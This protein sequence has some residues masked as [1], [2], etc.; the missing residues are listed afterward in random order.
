MYP[1]YFLTIFIGLRLLFAWK[2]KALQSALKG[3]IIFLLIT[4]PFLLPQIPGLPSQEVKDVLATQTAALALLPGLFFFKSSPMIFLSE[5][6]VAYIGL[7]TVILA[8]I[9]TIV[10]SS[11]TSWRRS[12]I[13]YLL[14]ALAF[15]IFAIGQYSPINFALLV[16]K[17]LPLSFFLRAPGRAMIIGSLAL[18]VCATIGFTVLIDYIKPKYKTLI[19]IAIVLVVFLDLT[20][21]YEPP[22]MSPPLQQN[23]AYKFLRD[24]PGDFRIVEVPSIYPQM[25]LSNMYT[26]H[27]VL[28]TYAWA[29]GYFDPLYVFA[30][31]YN[32]YLNLTVAEAEATLYGI[33][34]VLV[35][36]D[37]DYYTTLAPAIKYY[38]SPTLDQVMPVKDYLN[39]SEDYRLVYDKEDYSIYENLFYRGTV[40]PASSYTWKDPNTLIIETSNSKP[41]QIFISQSYTEGWIAEVNGIQTPI[42]EVDSIQSINIPA[43]DN[44]IVLHY[45]RYESSLLNFLVFYLAAFLAFLLLLRAKWKRTILIATLIYGIGL[46]VFSLTAYP[47]STPLYHTALT[48]LGIALTVGTLTYALLRRRIKWT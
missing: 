35:N 1:A 5:A 14:T 13:F 45:E 40:F 32:N 12:Y 18:S 31:Q 30:N 4:V 33:K 38:N 23:E 3:G 41:E 19:T 8:L 21:G 39:S 25:A 17:Y 6:S 16:Q 43:G 2:R 29:F 34:Y 44:R 28:S 22:A 9:P 48:S 36:I 37:P 7:A 47:Y 10:I 24:Q 20:V 27:D 11:I 26:D 15:I 42:H 46:T